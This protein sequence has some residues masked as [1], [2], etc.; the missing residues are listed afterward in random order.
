VGPVKGKPVSGKEIRCSTQTLSDGT[1]VT[2]SDTSYFFRDAKGRMRA[3]SP[4]TIEII[5]PVA[6]VQYE[7]NRVERTYRR[8]NVGSEPAFI[9]MAVSG[10]S[11]S[12]HVSSDP[13]RPG[14]APVGPAAS[15]G[16]QEVNGVMA[17]G[18]RVTIVIPAG[19]FGNDRDVKVVNERWY[20]DE[21]QVLIKS[22]NNDPRFGIN[23]YELTEINRA[24]P[25]RSLFD[26]PAGY[27]LVT[28]RNR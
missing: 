18:S 17:V 24:E 1:L 10:K 2:H 15:L 21:L 11:Y 14:M 20:S 8:F 28:R 23:T 19:S 12:T 6:Q 16:R 4:Q 13:P 3:E 25:D 22:V 26:P 7:V 9:S 5:D 27:T